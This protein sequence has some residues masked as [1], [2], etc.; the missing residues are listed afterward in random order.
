MNKYLRLC[1]ERLRSAH[2][3]HYFRLKTV[4]FL[5]VV[6][7]QGPNTSQC[8]GVRIVTG[9]II[10]PAKIARSHHALPKSPAHYV[11]T[12]VSSPGQQSVR[13]KPG[14]L[15]LLIKQVASN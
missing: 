6:R 10:G 12:T 13:R 15:G 11:Y 4:F 5:R 7:V 2:A 3:E 9:L 8:S 1:G 14:W